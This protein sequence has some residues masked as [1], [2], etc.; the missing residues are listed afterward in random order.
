MGI[1]IIHKNKIRGPNGFT[2]DDFMNEKINRTGDNQCAQIC[3]I[4]QQFS[5]NRLEKQ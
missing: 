2:Q 3:I 4:L 5:S 1:F